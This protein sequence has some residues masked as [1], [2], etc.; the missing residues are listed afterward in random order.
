MDQWEPCFISN[1]HSRLQ[2]FTLHF[3]LIEA[4]NLL[5]YFSSNI[6][7]IIIV[8]TTFSW[9]CDPRWNDS[10]SSHIS[11]QIDNLFEITLSITLVL[12][13]SPLSSL[14]PFLHSSICCSLVLCCVPWDHE[15]QHIDTCCYVTWHMLSLWLPFFLSTHIDFSMTFWKRGIKFFETYCIPLNILSV[16]RSCSGDTVYYCSCS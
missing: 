9:S 10:L 8:N 7:S 6:F 4:F 12:I 16:T 14:T 3:L 15:F 1:V 5:L 2:G 11:Y 13:T